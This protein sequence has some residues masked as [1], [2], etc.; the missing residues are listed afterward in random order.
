MLMG[1]Y[2][3]FNFQITG[4]FVMNDEKIFPMKDI[5]IPEYKFDKGEMNI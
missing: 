4:G 1:F 5:K 3:M 2:K